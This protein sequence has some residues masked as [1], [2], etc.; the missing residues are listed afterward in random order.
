[1]LHPNT[2][3]HRVSSSLPADIAVL[4]NPVA[5]GVRWAYSEP[6]LRMGDTIVVLGAG[7]RGLAC[8]IAARA[9]GARQIIVTDLA[10]S[11][12]KLEFALELGADAAWSP[13]RRTW[14]R[15]CSS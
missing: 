3:L 7:Q 6:S 9:A 1:M 12:D 8:V 4:F 15:A 13:T 5:A 14:S 11:S 2:R 10:R